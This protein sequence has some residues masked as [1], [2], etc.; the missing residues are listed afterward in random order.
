MPFGLRHRL[1]VAAAIVLTACG[2]ESP[3]LADPGWRSVAGRHDGNFVG[4]VGDFVELVGCHPMEGQ[5]DSATVALPSRTGGLLRYNCA[6]IPRDSVKT[7]IQ[8]YRTALK[9]SLG[10]ASAESGDP[11]GEGDGSFIYRFTSYHCEVTTYW[12]YVPSTW[13]YVVTGRSG[14]C[15]WVEHY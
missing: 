5:R 15:T 4:D 2:A 3:T 11:E 14:E 8:R 1:L 9:E 10:G 7:A 6:N 13:E 12:T